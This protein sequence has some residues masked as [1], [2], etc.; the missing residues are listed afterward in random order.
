MVRFNTQISDRHELSEKEIEGRSLGV[1]S[2]SMSLI[3]RYYVHE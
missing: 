3:S 1:S 2:D